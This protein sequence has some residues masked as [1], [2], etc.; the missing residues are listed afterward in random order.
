MLLDSDVT[1]F[2]PAKYR[3]FFLMTEHLDW[4]F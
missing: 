2:S 1:G 3:Q 4:M